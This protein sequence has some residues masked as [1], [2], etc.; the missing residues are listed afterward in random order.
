MTFRQNLR[1]INLSLLFCLALT[2][3]TISQEKV[4]LYYNALWEITSKEKAVYIRD[5]EFNLEKMQLAGKFTDSDLLGNKLMEGNYAAGR[6]NGEFTFFYPN[7]KIERKGTYQNNRRTGKWEYYYS[8]GKIKQ[9]VLFTPNERKDDFVVTDFFD[10]LGHQMIKEGTGKWI[11]DS[12]SYDILGNSSLQRLTGQFKDSL[13]VGEWKLVQID[14]NK[15]IHSER[16]VKGQFV[17]SVIFNPV[18]NDYGTTSSE[19]MPKLRDEY[20]SK[21]RKTESFV[22]DTTA[23][24]A[25]LMYAD[26]TTIL[27]TLTGNTYEIKNRKAM[28]PEGDYSLLEFIARNIKY[29]ISAIER[30]VTGKV[31]VGAF[32][33]SQGNLKEAKILYGID[34]EL[35][36]EALRVVRLIT[37]WLPEIVD[38]K[39]VQSALT[40]PVTFEI[41]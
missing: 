23:F 8:N 39:P 18:V 30:K 16:F 10:R 13:K 1:K 38:G 41:K 36:E 33:D 24:P 29:P 32:I 7:G 35:D 27:K 2:C 4:T 3:N 20:V 6:Q 28:Y 37:R 17:S 11:N 15:L 26:V 34:K 21:F 40:I 5:A 12:I 31:Y 25:S 14:N 22:L 9:L 19:F